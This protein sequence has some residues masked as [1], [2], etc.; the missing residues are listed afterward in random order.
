MF[1]ITRI[2]PLGST[3]TLYADTVREVESV[4]EVWAALGYAVMVQHEVCRI[5]FAEGD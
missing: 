3:V 2:T 5:T 4:I 1:K